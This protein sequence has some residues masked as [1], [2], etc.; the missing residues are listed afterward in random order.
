MENEN[1]KKLENVKYF[2]KEF[3]IKKDFYID[4]LINN[5]WH[6]GYIKEE[7][8]N[9]KYD[10][11]YLELANKTQ[12][13]SNISRKELSFFGENYY[14]NNNNIR[15]TFLNKNIKDLDSNELFNL[16]IEKLNEINL[17]YK[18]I[19]KIISKTEENQNN[20]NNN[21]NENYG[22][23]FNEENQKFIIKNENNI[24]YN[25]TGFYTYQFFS[26]MFVDALV[27]V[28]DNLSELIRGNKELIL[29]ESFE[30]LLILMLNITIFTLILGINKRSKIKEYIQFNR[31][32]IIINKTSSILSSIENIISNILIIFCYQYFKIP[33]IEFKLK[34]ICNLCYNILLNNNKEN[35]YIPIQFLIT[36]INFITYEDNIIR[37]KNFDKN[38]LYKIILTTLQ[39]ITGD[40]IKNIKNFS[41]IYI[42]CQ[43]IVKKLYKG[44]KK[45]LINN[46]YYFFLV[47][48]LKRSNILEKKIM[49]LN[50]INDIIKDLIEKEDEINIIFND[51]FLNK[52]KI[53]D[54]FFEE[55]VHDEILKRSIEIFK[56]LS[57]Y[58]MINE[59]LINK[60]IK[61]NDNNTIRNIL[62]EII[63]NL[64]NEDK[65]NYIFKNITKDFN[66]DNNNNRNNLIEFVSRLT[67][68]CFSSEER[69]NKNNNNFLENDI[70]NGNSSNDGSF[71]NKNIVNDN[72]SDSKRISINIQLLKSNGLFKNK[73]MK[74]NF[75]RNISSNSIEKFLMNSSNYKRVSYK[76]KSL[77]NNYNKTATK[78]YFGLN[79][80]FNYLVY[81]YNEVKALVSKNNINKAIKSFK[82]ILDSSRTI[83]IPDIYYFLD[84]LLENIKTNKKYN[85]II[86]SLNLMEILLNKLLFAND[87][88]STIYNLY[89]NINNINFN[90]LDMNEEEGEIISLLDNKYD[91]ISLIIND[92]VRYVTKVNKISNKKENYKNEI[93]EG[94]YPYIKNISIRLKLL[95]FFVNFGLLINVENHIGKIYSLFKSEEFKDEKL[96]FF[97][98]LSNNIDYISIETQKSIF[99]EIFQNSQQFDKSNFEE[100]D[101]FNL[102]KELFINI[103]IY[104]GSIIGDAK[105]IKVTKDLDKLEGI[106]FLFEILISNRNHFIRNKLCKI[107]SKYCLY[108]SYY[109][110]DFCNKYWN[111][112]IDKITDLLYIC[113]KNKNIT[114]IIGLVQLIESIYIYNFSG[115]IPEKE[116][117]HVAEEPYLLYYFCCP[118]RNDKVYKLRVGKID[119]MVQMRWKLA[120]YYDICVNDLVICD[121][122]KN[123][124]NFT[125]D[126]VIFYEI[127]PPRKYLLGE[128]K[129]VLIK[130]YEYPGQLLK[131]PNNPKELIEKNEK[132]IEILISNLSNNCP[133]KNNKNNKDELL[134]KKKIWNMIQKLPKKTYIR[135]LINKYIENKKIEEEDLIF[136]FSINEIFI[137][138]FNLEC[139]LKFLH[140]EPEKENYKDRLKE[141]NDFLEFFINI[142]HIDKT[143]YNN[144]LII[145]LNDNVINENNKFIYFECF[146][147]LIELIQ[148]IEEYKK[149]TTVSSIFYTTNR[150]KET[151]QPKYENL[152]ENKKDEDLEITKVNNSFKNNIIEI[153]GNKILYKKLTDIIIIIL[154][155]ND[156]SNELICFNLLQEIIKLIEQLKNYYLNNITI[157]S[158]F[159]SFFEYIFQNDELFKEIFIYDFIKC[160]KEEVKKLLSNFL[161]QN[162]FDNYLFVK[163]KFK[164]KDRDNVVQKDITKSKYIKNY[165]DI[166]LTPEIFQYLIKNKTNASY[167][168]LISSII[169]KYI[170]YNKQLNRY[171]KF[172]DDETE[173]NNSYNENLKNIINSIINFLNNKNKNDDKNNE[174]S[175]S[176]LSYPYEN[177][178]SPNE[179]RN[180]NKN[181]KIKENFLINGILLYLLKLLEFSSYYDNSLV[182][183]FLEKIDVHEFFLIK[184]ILKKNNEN[185]LNNKNSELVNINSH[186]IIFQII[187]FLLK[188]LDNNDNIIKDNKYSEDSLYMK[189]WLTLNKFHKLAFWKKNTNFEINYYDSDKKEFV[190]LKNMSSTCYMNSIIQQFFMI[191]ML[192]ETILSIGE[193][194]KNSLH[195][196]TILYQLQLLFSS[197]K[198]YD[199]KYY[200]PKHFVIVSKLSFYEQMDADEYYCQLID[201]LE[202]DISYL[203]NNDINKNN[204]VDLFKY[205]FG[206]KLTDELYFIECEHKRFNESFCYNIQLEV[207]NYTNINDSLKNY[208]K[209]EIMAGD[210]KINCEE[211]CSKRVCHKQLKIKNLPNILVISL[212]RF[213]YDYRTMTK[214]KLNSYFEFPFKLD[215]SEY[216]IDSN[217]NNNTEVENTE[218]NINENNLY[219]LT[220]ITIHYGVSDYGHYYDII[221]AE[222]NKWY[223]FNDTNIKE[224]PEND[225]PK[226]AFGERENNN[227]FDEEMSDKN[228]IVHKDKKNAYILIYTKINFKKNFSKNNEYKT[229]LIFPPYDKFSNINE[230]NK[231]IINYKMFK[232]WALEN[233]SN[234]V[235]QNFIIDLLKF[236]LV[237]NINKEIEKEHINLIQDLKNEDYLPIKNYINTGNTIFS[238]GLLYFFN[239]LLKSPKDKNILKIYIDIL[240]VYLENDINKCFYVLEEFSDSEVI[241]EFLLSN[242]NYEV[243]KII[244]ELIIFCFNN[245]SSNYANEKDSE[246]KNLNLFKYLNSI[247]LFISEKSYSLSSNIRSLDNIIKLFC[248]LINKKKI[249]LKYL[250]NKGIDNWLDEI[251]NKINNNNCK[252]E[253][254]TIENNEDEDENIN[255]NILL[256]EANFPKLTSE[257]CI[258]KEKISEYNFGFKFQKYSKKYSIKIKDNSKKGKISSI[259][260]GDSIV[261]LR[262]LQDDLREI[263]V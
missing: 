103:N 15:E 253:M 225:I 18:N 239:I 120:Y 200:N 34:I 215:M 89:Q 194:G 181:E 56:Y 96:L 250:K 138:T 221:K 26:G 236:D 195:H 161:V 5:N 39:N 162:L 140:I 91:I 199:F 125:Y 217:N 191:P 57:I 186:K 205:F 143:L 4:I 84:K 251:I 92:L 36:I 152:N 137:L 168:N 22:N 187:I 111:N 241:D 229:K 235:Y 119:K 248:N 146:E 101:T 131:I 1:K 164:I 214:F 67:L 13:K 102:I 35:N 207:K 258:L 127:F 169:E 8:L 224:F 249:Y 21:F 105:G 104:K 237:K 113:N 231:S 27:Y 227:D 87:K 198:A 210:N 204:Y 53:M 185:N 163:N 44:E 234:S 30:K 139:I 189:I 222:N 51:F 47:I 54:I 94:I 209:I 61:L 150:D 157:S 197:L 17:D 100:I 110:N 123:E 12:I 177:K 95:F 97:R 65:K 220:G 62:C 208:F 29:E 77:K 69:Q 246:H 256:T 153:I 122:D 11:L 50:C 160:P 82:F 52:N 242:K 109:N 151:I 211:C 78:N 155:D 80:L 184:I 16:L 145:D 233:L 154:N 213:D 144:L 240:N 88:R 108:L 135:K 259:N 158:T 43:T 9:N 203:Y 245:Y 178:S 142:H 201:K 81:D 170:N 106:N 244:S 128:G 141:I 72:I 260:S 28:N 114:G 20:N 180:I 32:N 90:D 219:E 71:Y 148:I 70:T 176:L 46:C 243:I 66:F 226:E 79:L 118:Q 130:V 156:S 59:E 182:N 196:N 263:D 262:R 126:N 86:Q 76:K 93:F 261:L 124:Y 6:Q 2:P 14:Q 10:I 165:F 83:K 136:K 31:L 74:K 75:S 107:L 3:L 98:E 55:T 147:S 175:H 228:E 64:K 172:L 68:A 63:K 149:K 257:H 58:D 171:T 232:Y 167:F 188:Y 134:I 174:N 179:S 48:C 183:Y 166:I 192:R 99:Y 202:N 133:I 255:M 173:K 206:I 19:E 159:Q 115:K 42:D 24:E 216:L 25:I 33:N 41:Q 238:F 37:I 85:S 190:G 112:Y 132:I 247:I 116:E 38:K 254:N 40:D 117:T 7:K 193:E 129:H 45:V 252:S 73:K 218:N 49:A 60:L 223:M 121:K 212:K 230:N 23:L